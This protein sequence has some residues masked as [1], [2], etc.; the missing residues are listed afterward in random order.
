V[1]DGVEDLVGGFGPDERGI[2]V[3]VLD[4]R[5]DVGVELAD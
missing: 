1:G 5:S 3:A 2:L 4:P